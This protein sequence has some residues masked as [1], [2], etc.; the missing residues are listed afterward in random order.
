MYAIRTT[1]VVSHLR[2][3]VHHVLVSARPRLHLVPFR[4][5]FGTA[6]PP[7]SGEEVADGKRPLSEAVQLHLEASRVHY[8]DVLAKVIAQQEV[9]KRPD[10]VE[11]LTLLEELAEEHAARPAVD[12]WGDDDDARFDWQTDS[13][14]RRL[15]A[16]KRR[17]RWGQ[18]KIHQIRNAIDARQAEAKARNEAEAHAQL[19]GR[20][21]IHAEGSP[22][23]PSG[24]GDEQHFLIAK[25]VS[26]EVALVLEK[27]LLA[28]V[29]GT[30]DSN[31]ELHEDSKMTVL[32]LIQPRCPDE[33]AQLLS[34]WPDLRRQLRIEERFGSDK[35]FCALMESVK[36]GRT[37]CFDTKRYAD[38][39]DELAD[40]YLLP[41]AALRYSQDVASVV[42]ATDLSPAEKTKVIEEMKEEKE[43]FE[44]ELCVLVK[45]VKEVVGPYPLNT[46]P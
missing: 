20:E 40:R 31:E 14:E 37:Y 11:G 9:A 23:H 15:Q 6:R 32:G 13:E 5:L 28:E 33:T 18:A 26:A 1:T 4:Y 35:A 42:S 43:Q 38:H 2:R 39:I 10:V 25:A 8:T 41:L 7:P 45:V 46:T 3:H 12:D 27:V 22:A 30:D 17:L 36:S 19:T 29:F 24:Q 21:A 44:K 34:T 16:I